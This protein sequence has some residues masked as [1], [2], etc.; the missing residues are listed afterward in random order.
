MTDQ[1]QALEAKLGVTTDRHVF[2]VIL[3]KPNPGQARE[4]KN[5][6]YEGKKHKPWLNQQGAV[7]VIYR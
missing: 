3:G 7:T 1:V 4:V 2:T 6:A 5:T